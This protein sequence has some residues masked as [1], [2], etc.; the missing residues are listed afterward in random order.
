MATRILIGLILVAMSAPVLAGVSGKGELGLVVARGN[1]ET[2]TGNVRFELNYE[3]ER[4]SNESIITAVYGRDSGQTNNSRW[5]LSNN[6]NYDLSEISYLV[7][8]LRYDR[9]RFSSFTYQSTV[10]VGYGHRLIRTERH[11]LKA[12]IGPG[13]RF[14]RLRETD[15]SENEAILRGFLNY[16]WQ[17][18]DTTQLTNRF[19]VESGSD[20]TF[21]ENTLGLSVA[22][23]S[24]VSLKTGF[25]VRHNTEVDP[26]RKKTDTLTTVNLVYNF[27]GD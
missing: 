17:V 26:G 19:L 21:L 22:V 2:E 23:N 13:F 9:D 14:A 1:S 15:E 3:R 16:R 18:S 8:A 7:G 27:G 20:N 5:V 12:E 11:R 6:T 24:R 25:S 4:W 10:A